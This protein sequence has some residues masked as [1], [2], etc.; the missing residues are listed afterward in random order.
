MQ[1]ILLA[2]LATSIAFGLAKLGFWQLDRAEQ[3]RQIL[4]LAT[5]AEQSPAVYYNQQDLSEKIHH[6]IIFTGRWNNKQ[7]FIYDN[8]TLGGKSG[9]F[10]LTP[11]ITAGGEALLVNRGFVPWGQYRSVDANLDIVDKKTTIKVKISAIPKRVQLKT[12]IIKPPFPIVIQGIDLAKIQQLT[13]GDF[14]PILGLLSADD[15][16]GFIRGWQPFYG[17]VEKHI[18]YAVQWFLMAFVFAI[19]AIYFYLKKIHKPTRKPH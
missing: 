2:L 7:Q 11:F 17:S 16:N 5:L 15:S 10:V 3:K 1:K 8:Q 18:G 4:T 6:S 9:Y 13:G 19:L 12:E 14:L